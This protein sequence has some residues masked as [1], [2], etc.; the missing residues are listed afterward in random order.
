MDKGMHLGVVN[1]VGRARREGLGINAP[2]WGRGEVQ[3]ITCLHSW[4]FPL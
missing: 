3:V 4:A 1:E 2:V